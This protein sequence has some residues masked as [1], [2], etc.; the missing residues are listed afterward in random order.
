MKRRLFALLLLIGSL[1][2]V[3]CNKSNPVSPTPVPPEPPV[4][5]E[6]DFLDF[7]TFNGEFDYSDYGATSK[8][9]LNMA[10]I[11]NK[12]F[13][14][15][16]IKMNVT[17]NNKQQA[18]F[19]F[20]SGTYPDS[21]YFLCL[22]SSIGNRLVLIKH[23][24][25][26]DEEMGSCYITA[27]YVVTSTN[28]LK[29]VVQNNKIQ[30]FWNDKLFISRTD[31]DFLTGDR[32]GIRSKNAGTIYADINISNKNEFKT[33]ETLITGHSY[34]ELWK[35]YKKDLS[36]Y[37]DIQNIGIGGSAS[38]DWVNHVSEVID[39]HPTNLVY[40]MGINDVGRAISPQQFINNV[41]AYINPILTE[42][43][44]IK[45]CLVSIN[46]CPIYADSKNVI[47][48]MNRELSNYVFETDNV[49]YANIDD[50]FLNN[51][52]TPDPNC[53]VDGLHPTESAYFTIRDAIYDA[54]DNKNQP[55]EYIPDAT[56]DLDTG[57]AIINEIKANYQ[58]TTW[59]L[60]DN[61]VTTKSAGHLLSTSTF[62]NFDAV[63]D[64]SNCGDDNPFFTHQANKSFLFGGSEV[65][66]K[67]KGYAL[68]ICTD[69]IEILYLDGSEN[70]SS[71]FIGAIQAHLAGLK[72]KLTV[73]DSKAYIR[74]ADG[75]EI[76]SYFDDVD[77]ISLDSYSGGK[78]GFLANNN[79][80]T[81]IGLYEIK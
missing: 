54:F 43:S 75:T 53:F 80:Q 74:Y 42:L 14:E 47:K 46:Q 70:Y 44:D 6:E 59:E 68:D 18:G 26:T 30:C 34:M 28:E 29:A 13:T 21:Y 78:I 69:W 38:S 8:S 39:Y 33:V 56:Y 5:V 45:V 60:N 31:R 64:F 65:D 62:I 61:K 1:T 57:K 32:V 66:G 15:G 17:A 72:I 49:Y 73:S 25:N 50:A 24:N 79:Q 7:Q 48:E 81:D 55:Q 9:S 20:G 63:I 11:T 27:G 36:R 2:F 37:P 3:G 23:S 52:G 41:K 71:T 58:D 67:Y 40:M 10:L 12:T 22:D 35:N 77:Y 16:T 51:D 19:I 4:P 76:G